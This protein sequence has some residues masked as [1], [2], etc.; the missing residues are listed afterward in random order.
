MAAE[1]R[2]ELGN[3][4]LTRGLKELNKEGQIVNFLMHNKVGIRNTKE[5]V[6]IINY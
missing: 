6:S 2:L 4:E 3:G 5:K 1:F